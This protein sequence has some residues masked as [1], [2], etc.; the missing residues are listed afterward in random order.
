MLTT[1]AQVKDYLVGIGE[2]VPVTHDALLDHMIRRQSAAVEQFCRRRFAT[3]TVTA[4]IHTG[5]VEQKTLYPHQWPVTSWTA[6]SIDGTVIT[7][8]T[9][10][11]NYRQVKNVDT[12]VVALY[13]E[14]T[15]SSDPFGVSLTYVAG[16]VLPAIPQVTP[17]TLPYDLEGAV[18]ELSAGMYLTRG[19]VGVTRES[20]EGLSQD[21]DRWPMHI[22]HVLRKFQRP[23]I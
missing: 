10:N 5:D 19:K 11:A 9:G 22:L 23:V 21:Y 1:V 4:E 17:R 16:Y 20:F 7:E 15:W 13:R 3:A 12:D 8:G 18:V 6:V 14:N 2:T